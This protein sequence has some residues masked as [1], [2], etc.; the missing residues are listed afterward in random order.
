MHNFLSLDVNLMNIIA[1]LCHEIGAIKDGK[2]KI[3]SFY[4]PRN[5][6]DSKQQRDTLSLF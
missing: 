4:D 6:N 2:L 3:L 1:E 5:F